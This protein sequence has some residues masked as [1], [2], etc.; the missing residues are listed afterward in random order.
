[1][2]DRWEAP[3]KLNFHLAVGPV[4]ATGYHPIH[5]IVQTI[6]WCD[7]LDVEEAADDE[8]EV[9]GSDVVPDDG[10][11]LV[12]K[13]LAAVRHP[14][15]RL[16]VI[17]DKRIPEAAGLGGGSSDAAAVLLAV[18]EVTGWR[19]PWLDAAAV[20]TGADIRYLLD[21]GSAA[22][23]GYGE[24]VTR[25]E[26]PIRGFAVSVAVPPFPLST[27]AV[28]RHWDE[29]GGPRGAEY[30]DRHLPPALRG[31][32]FRNDLLPAALSLRP[33]LGDWIADLAGLW[34]TTVA[35]SGS[36][37]AL[38]G[39]FPTVEEAVA[40][41]EAVPEDARASAGA[42]LRPTGPGRVGS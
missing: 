1:M 12:W 3:A 21:G 13:V 31:E 11:N 28:Y 32:S 16:R 4:D 33:E 36:G 14:R 23:A 20:E 30:P 27:P 7:F 18:S 40:A 5:S 41:A 2:G 6:E 35:M 34:G 42:A 22:M 15:P 26:Q 9:I 10:S 24:R 38:F 8:L 39:W 37:P 25:L 29:I 17:L 19:R